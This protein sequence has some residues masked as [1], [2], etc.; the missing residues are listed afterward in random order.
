VLREERRVPLEHVGAG[1]D[2]DVGREGRMRGR[3]VVALEE[4]LDGALPVRLHPEV[5]ARVEQQPSDVEL[6]RK[7]PKR[8]AERPR[9]RVGV[10]PQER[11]PRVHARSDERDVVAVAVELLAPRRSAERPVELVRP[12]VVGAL[13]R[14][15]A[16]RSLDEDRA[17]VP[18]HVQER[19]KLSRTVADDEDGDPAGVDRDE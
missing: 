12:R 15:A 11:T 8:V 17:A 2:V 10:H 18:A 19:A 6:R 4:V 9:V 1:P 16:A 7:R 3:A 14:V 13:D 5:D